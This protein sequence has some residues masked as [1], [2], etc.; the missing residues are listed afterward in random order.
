[1]EQRRLIKQTKT[2]LIN[3][4]EKKDEQYSKIFLFFNKNDNKEREFHITHNFRT[5]GP[6]V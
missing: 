2:T 1:M 6:P 4:S 5:L 3:I